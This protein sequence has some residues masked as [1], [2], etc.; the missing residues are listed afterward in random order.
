MGWKRDP[1]GIGS[2]QCGAGGCTDY[3]VIK[4]YGTQYTRK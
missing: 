3:D 1:C 2:I 4:S